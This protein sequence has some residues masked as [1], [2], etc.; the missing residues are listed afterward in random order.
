MEVRKHILIVDDDEAIRA[1]LKHVLESAGYAT[2]LAGDGE[3]ALAVLVC[4]DPDLLILDL[5]LP[6]LSGWDILESLA[7]TGRLCPVIVLT[8]LAAQCEPGDSGN[9]DVLLEK[10]PEVPLLLEWVERLLRE[11][12]EVRLR[13]KLALRPEL[14]VP[15]YLRWSNTES[16]VDPVKLGR[17]PN[18]P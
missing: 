16:L 8:A 18:P 3:K 7:T 2:C 9:A 12:P 13:R 1:S 5:D 10:P 4:A 14:T 15:G 11:P 6:R 17:P